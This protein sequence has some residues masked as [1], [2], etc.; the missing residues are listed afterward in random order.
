MASFLRKPVPFKEAA[1]WIRN[2]PA[3][4]REAFDKLLP[5]LKPRA[6]TITG[7]RSFDVLEDIQRAIAT[8]PEVAI[9]DD[10]RKDIAEKLFPDFIDPQAD[11]EMQAKQRQ[12]A[13]RRAELLIRTQGFQAYQ[14]ANHEA[15][16]RNT[17]ALPYWQYLSMED[18][19]VRPSHAALNGIVLPAD[20]PFWKSH[21]PPWE[22]GCRC[23]VVPLSQTDVEGIQERDAALPEDER[24]ILSPVSVS[25]L[26][27]ENSLARKGNF[28]N[29]SS[30]AQKGTAGAFTFDPH[31]LR[32]PLE[33]IRDRYSPSVWTAFEKWAKSAPINP[34]AGGK[35]IWEWLNA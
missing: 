13:I 24:R 14:A 6:F 7:V 3:V 32:L 30:A 11:E 21:F 19:R 2:K 17:D 9:W 16:S 27:T 15:M 5:E 35:T 8:I 12:A 29:V 25:K 28:Y 1:D 22:W 33:S 4:S 31:S 10:V 23:Q 26:E 20:S 34:G 18:S